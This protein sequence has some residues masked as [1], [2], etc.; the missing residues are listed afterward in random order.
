MNFC[1]AKSVWK[2]DDFSFTQSKT[3]DSFPP[4]NGGA[5]IRL[6]SSGQKTQKTH[7]PHLWSI[8]W[9]WSEEVQLVSI[10]RNNAGP[11]LGWTCSCAPMPQLIEI[12]PTDIRWL[13]T[14]LLPASSLI[15]IGLESDQTTEQTSEVSLMPKP[16][17][18]DSSRQN[19]V[20]A[21]MMM[22]M[23][24]IRRSFLALQGS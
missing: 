2:Q 4:R 22:M 7:Q 21:E 20:S 24:S 13:R 23:K 17:D 11:V 6:S 5:G 1:F 3:H 14:N 10:E 18:L 15:K 9:S 12:L 16:V 19:I 8:T